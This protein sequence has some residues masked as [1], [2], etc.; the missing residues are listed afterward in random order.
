M[1]TRR[2]KPIAATPRLATEKRRRNED[3][4]ICGHDRLEPAIGNLRL[5]TCKMIL[6]ARVH[7]WSINELPSFVEDLL[8][9]WS[10][11]S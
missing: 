6:K 9:P 10:L 3:W 11:L 4:R 7:N 1:Y 5:S 2:E 8:W